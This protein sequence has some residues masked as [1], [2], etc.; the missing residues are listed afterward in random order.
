MI[1]DLK[2][3]NRQ[4]VGTKGSRLSNRDWDSLFVVASEP[5]AAAD[6]GRFIGGSWRGNS[7][8]C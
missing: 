7:S 6:I 5:N 3:G 4:G 8:E 1:Q 2:D